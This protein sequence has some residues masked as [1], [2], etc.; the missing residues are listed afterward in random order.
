MTV[1]IYV[2]KDSEGKE[3]APD[4]PHEIEGILEILQNIWRVYHHL[5]G[6]YLVI[7]NM[8]SPH[9]DLV[10]L[11][12]RGLGVMELKH[13]FGHISIHSDGN[14]YANQMR[15]KGGSYS[16]PHKQVQ[17]YSNKIRQK[18]LPLVLPKQM[19]RNPSQWNDFKFQTAVCFTNP[20]AEL[21]EIRGRIHQPRFIHRQPWEDDFSILV[22]EESP[23][24]IAKLRFGMDLGPSKRYEP[25]RLSFSTLENCV[26]LVF[27]GLEWDEILGTMPSGEPYAYLRMHTTKGQQTFGLSQ[28]F[29]NIGRNPQNDI[30][31]PNQLS[32]V[33]KRHCQ[34]CRTIHG[35]EIRD[36]DS[37]NDT[38]V[39]GKLINKPVKLNHDQRIT[40]GSAISGEKV[41]TLIFEFREQSLI[42]SP[43]TENSDE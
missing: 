32:R 20:R 29:I 19:K 7:A 42:Q 39:D 24:W 13:H 15:I 4:H 9:A 27:G 28:N 30:V 1:K 33:S 21:D 40:L 36:L 43:P 22:Q 31:I 35:V 23:G 16:N 37:T 14:W 17:T 6:V 8:Q 5:Q 38:Y 18:L 12:E 34:I 11:T 10:V 3:W 2:A 41:C 26:T 25:Y